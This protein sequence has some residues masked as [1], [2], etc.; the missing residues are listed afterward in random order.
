MY[1]SQAD[2]KQ[3][4]DCLVPV[5]CHKYH[6]CFYY[7]TNIENYLSYILEICE[8]FHTLTY[9]DKELFSDQETSETSDVEMTVLCP[10]FEALF[11][12]K[13]WQRVTSIGQ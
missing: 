5:K 12:K 7:D 6:S 1:V 3:F 2:N 10:C 9:L 4:V 11:Q 13:S 8:T